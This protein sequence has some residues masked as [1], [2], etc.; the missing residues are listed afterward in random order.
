[1]FVFRNVIQIHHKTPKISIVLF[2]WIAREF[3]NRV[4]PCY[5]Y[6]RWY[7]NNAW[8]TL[9]IVLFFY[10]TKWRYIYQKRSFFWV[11]SQVIPST[12][13]LRECLWWAPNGWIWV[14]E[15]L[16]TP[17]NSSFVTH[18]SA[19]IIILSKNI[20]YR[21]WSYTAPTFFLSKSLQP[22][23]AKSKFWSIKTILNILKIVRRLWNIIYDAIIYRM[24]RCALW[25]K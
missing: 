22:L 9:T 15:A 3:I 6:I 10:L 4:W 14:L 20:Q 18:L 25:R 24:P 13:G 5:L 7:A 19:T 17:R 21:H 16:L 1:M 2:T 11:S 8:F 23:S 12:T